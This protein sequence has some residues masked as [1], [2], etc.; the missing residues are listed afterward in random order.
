VY[1]SFT[2][3]QGTT[4]PITPMGISA[5]R[6]LAS[7][8]T[9][10]ALFP[11]PDPLYGPPFV[12][13]AASRVFFDVTAALRRSFGRA[14]LTRRLTQAEAHAATIFQQLIS[15]PPRAAAHLARAAH[16]LAEQNGW[17]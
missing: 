13:E 15:D 10:F 2:L 5:I 9:A 1:L 7:A 3:Q 17:L 4:Q 6:L 11:P 8:I 16:P 12:T 14:L